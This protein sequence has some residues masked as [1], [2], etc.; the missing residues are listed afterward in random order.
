MTDSPDSQPTEAL[1]RRSAAKTSTPD[2][3]E[4]KTGGLGALIAKHP[5]AWLA[6]ALAVVFLLLGTAA[7]FAGISVGSASVA[8]P[9]S[10]PTP[11]PTIEPRTQPAAL[12]GATRLRTCSVSPLAGDPRLTTFAGY[13]MNVNTGETLY[14][15][16]G[17]TPQRTGSVLKVVTAAAALDALGSG[18]QL[19][20]QVLEG[21]S[22]GVIVLKGGGDPTLATTS[23]TVYSGAPLISDL[24]N[25]AM[26]AYNA[27]YPDVPI[28]QLILD[29]NMWNPA[30]RWDD[31]WLRKE[32]SDGYQA[33]VAALMVDG[34]RA[35]PTSTVSSR[36]GDPIGDA[37]RAFISA[38][39][40]DGVAVS[41]SSGDNGVVLAE[42]KS[43]PL[44]VLVDQMMSWSDNIL[45]EQ[46]ARVTSKAVGFDG[47]SSSLGLAIPTALQAYGL[48]LSKVTIR[49]GSGLSDLNAV[50]PQW[51]SQLMIKVRAGEGNLGIIYESLPVAG[52][53]GTLS[54][55]FTGSNSIAAGNVV[56]KTGWLDSAYTL[57]GIVQAQDGTP[58]SFMITSIR[59]GISSDAKEAQDSVVTGFFLCGDN[60][61]NH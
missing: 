26:A 59:D 41:E 20:T 57:S 60:L 11:T 37:G 42:V 53:S 19:S 5:T 36:T 55:R 50:S 33:E 2:G 7:V 8:A 17:T 10:T 28:T 15:Y 1:T 54:S 12:P 29:S 4:A 25:A 32:Q 49:D 22:P 44:S 38:A 31:S 34:G 24:A 46:L 47:S 27:K 61:S 58:L 18:A 9:V 3:A 14:D 35:D 23:A 13:V 56:A 16:N 48:D 52:I 40:L 45:A 51:M 30:D 6:S 43:Q 39:G 21:T